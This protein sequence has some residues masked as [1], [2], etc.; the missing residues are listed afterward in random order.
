MLFKNKTLRIYRS[1]LKLK[2]INKL[3]VIPNIRF[4]IEKFSFKV[5]RNNFFFSNLSKKDISIL[6]NQITKKQIFNEKLNRS[7]L[8]SLDNKEYFNNPLP[9]EITRQFKRSYN[10]KVN[11]K[12]SHFR[13]Y[14]NILYNLIKDY[15][16]FFKIVK[17]KKN[18]DI[19]EDSI[20]ISDFSLT[21][22]NTKKKYIS[23]HN[24][25][26]FFKNFVAEKFDFKIKNIYQQETQDFDFDGISVKKINIFSL[27]NYLSYIKFFFIFNLKFF[28]SLINLFFGNWK[29]AISL[30][31][32]IKYDITLYKKKK[33]NNFELLFFDSSQFSYKPIWTLNFK[34]KIL[35]TYLSS[36][37]KFLKKKI[38]EKICFTGYYDMSWNNII[39]WNL[40]QKNFL[41]KFINKAK[42]IKFHLSGPVPTNHFKVP[43]LKKSEKY[44]CIFDVQPYS[45]SKRISHGL[46]EDYYNFKN[47]R[48]FINDILELSKKLKFIILFKRKR[49][50]QQLDQRYINFLNLIKR[51]KNFIELN[52]KTSIFEMNKFSKCSISMPFTGAGYFSEEQKKKNYFYDAANELNKNYRNLIFTYDD[53]Y[54]KVKKQLIS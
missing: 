29:Y 15:F 25:I 41:K 50:S 32:I 45:S 51:N 17:L 23:K 54:R 8:L 38:N 14:I 36:N 3:E 37:L 13:W 10:L 2:R 35:L 5:N 49:N 39:V 33:L 30:I 48:K 53:L 44:V 16:K 47:S 43:L 7:I 18:L 52:V 21:D 46:T 12:L 27:D 6:I 24:I 42:K 11:K 4:R 40:N 28:I 31:E 1:F 20:F 19:N 9:S 26:S 34:K 22:F